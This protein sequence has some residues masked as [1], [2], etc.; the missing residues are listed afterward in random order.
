VGIV[1]H[2][3][4]MEKLRLFPYSGS[5][6]I[7]RLVRLVEFVSGRN[8]SRS[9]ID[10]TYL[11]SYPRSGNTWV[12]YIVEYISGRKTLGSQTN[13]EDLPLYIN[14][15]ENNPLK[16]VEELLP[17]ILYKSHGELINFS[18]KN[19][20]VLITRSPSIAI[21]RQKGKLSVLELIRYMLILSIYHQWE[22][23]RHLV[24]YEDLISQPDIVIPEL[25][26]FLEIDSSRIGELIRDYHYHKEMSLHLYS[27][28]VEITG[29]PAKG[30][31]RTRGELK[32]EEAVERDNRIIKRFM[33][34]TRNRHLEQYFNY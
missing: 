7:R 21:R 6:W 30:R 26:R 23:R 1:S 31:S 13:P 20:L 29:I 2:S 14:N 16:H 12:R 22:G 9:Q 33:Y 25:A 10:K 3:I 34:V 19:G 17:P 5:R 28:G 32:K 27:G 4:E 24:K 18:Q 11:L 8:T 15:V